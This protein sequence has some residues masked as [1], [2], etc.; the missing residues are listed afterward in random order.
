[1]ELELE[2]D[3]LGYC[4]NRIDYFLIISYHGNQIMCLAGFVF[5]LLPVI[6]RQQSDPL[7]LIT[8]KCISESTVVGG[9]MPFSCSTRWIVPLRTGRRNNR[10]LCN[11]ALRL[12]AFIA[13][14]EE[15]KTTC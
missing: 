10:S 12:S 3:G 7:T 2:R 14:R 13:L 5:S 8:S 6:H 15:Q 11:L 1:M 4:L 9:V